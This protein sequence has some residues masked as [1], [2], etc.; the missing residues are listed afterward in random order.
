LVGALA[1]DRNCVQ[2]HRVRTRWF[3]WTSVNE[4]WG[5]EGARRPPG[6]AVGAQGGSRRKKGHHPETNRNSGPKGVSRSWFGGRMT[7]R[8]TNAWPGGFFFGAEA[9]RPAGP[10]P[11]RQRSRQTAGAP[12]T[13]DCHGDG[14]VGTDVRLN[15]GA[16]PGRQDPGPVAAG[17]T[18]SWQGRSLVQRF[19]APR[20]FFL[21]WNSVSQLGAVPGPRGA[22]SLAL[23]AGPR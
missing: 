13:R 23:G 21:C 12:P 1:G 19:Q 18:G 4:E 7:V 2:H 22:G 10:L 6:Q 16:V 8:G 15:S 3:A 17:P 20:F 5:R 11:R 14:G 9:R